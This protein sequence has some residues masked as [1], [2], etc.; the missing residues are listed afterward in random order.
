MC[1]LYDVI[2]SLNKR[3][4][5][6]S[7]VWIFFE[8]KVGRER[9]F[10]PFRR[11][12]HNTAFM[13]PNLGA[14][15]LRQKAIYFR[16]RGKPYF[17]TV[18]GIILNYS[19]GNCKRIGSKIRKL[20]TFKDSNCNTYGASQKNNN[21]WSQELLHS[22]TAVAERVKFANAPATDAT[23]VNL[24]VGNIRELKARKGAG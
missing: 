2:K 16:R 20:R 9:Y 17:H 8:A 12:C 1:M 21:S 24:Q 19:A 10:N 23:T 4:L 18:R 14:I 5:N 13:C 3:L 22:R 6:L 7:C 15:L 11:L